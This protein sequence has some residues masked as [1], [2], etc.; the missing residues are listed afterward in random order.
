MKHFHQPSSP[1]EALVIKEKYG[2]Q[3][4]FV[5]G[6][7]QV[8]SCDFKETFTHAISLEGI[9]SDT[10]SKTEH[11]LEIGA[12]CTFQQLINDPQVPQVIKN[13]CRLITSRN[14]RNRVTIGGHIGSNRSNGVLLPVLLALNT[15]IKLA[16][17][18]VGIPISDFLLSGKTSLVLSAFIPSSELK[19]F[20]S[21]KHYR[22]SAND[23]CILVAA[24]S[25]FVVNQHF[26]NPL[27]ALG[28][29]EETAIRL[30]EIESTL[31][32]HM[33]QN[34][35]SVELQVASTVHPEDSIHCSAPFKKHLAGVLVAQALSETISMGGA[36]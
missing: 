31:D 13:A 24:A 34:T 16:T 19:R 26:R 3:S 32:S 36:S 30:Y 12:N 28:G 18:Q 4:V 29:V 33:L 21:I 15:T 22:R 1:E 20:C 23:R 10:I 35:D 27:I 6:G 25:S 2:N 9:L 5:S 14:I 17:N 8:N 7:T 11:G